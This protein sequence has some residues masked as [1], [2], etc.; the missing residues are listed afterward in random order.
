[1]SAPAHAA[2]RRITVVSTS[3]ADYG[4]LYW[5]LRELADAPDVELRIL[6]I[7]AH[8]SPRF[9]ETWR[10]FEAD[11]FVLDGVIECLLDSDSDVG[12]A[13]T[14]GMATLG[15]ADAL[16][17]DRPDLLLLI[18]DRYEMLAPASVALALRIPV[19]H[20]EGG[21]I[22]EGA[23]DDAVRH[24]LTKMAHLHLVPTT[25]AARRVRAMGEEAWRVHCTGAPS[26]DHL[27]RSRLPDGDTVLAD[28]DLPPDARPLVVAWHPVTLLNDPAAEA[29]PLFAALEDVDAPV[30]FCFPNADAGRERIIR[31]AEAFLATHPSARLVVNLEHLRYWALLRRAAVLLGNSSSGIMETPSLALPCVNIGDRQQGRQR[32]ANIIDVPADAQAIREALRRARDPQWTASLRGM[33]N[34]Y[35]E[36]DAARRIVAV[37]RSVSIDARLLRK[38]ALPLASDRDA[39]VQ[40]QDR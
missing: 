10:R 39:F 27:M 26:L 30:V 33:R 12:M 16:A 32:A 25:D 29:G 34:P 38:R 19:A 35:G 2:R 40:A 9:G 6:A 28:L 5:V 8:A 36:G 22:S 20:I 4:H 1:M 14:I 15:L 31:L 11:G 37:L 17:R 24:A 23:V 3:R 13:K 18:A 21:E 7:G